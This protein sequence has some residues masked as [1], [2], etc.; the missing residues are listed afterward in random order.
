MTSLALG[1]TMRHC[2]ACPACGAEAPPARRRPGNPSSSADVLLRVM[3]TRVKPAYDAVVDDLKGFFLFFALSK[4]LGIML[5]PTNFLID[6]G[7]AG[8]VLL[9]TGLAS[10]GRRL[11]TVSLVLLALFGFSP[12][13]SLL[14]YPLESRFAPWDE[15]RGAPDGIVVLG[16]SIDPELSA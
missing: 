10:L 3:D 13:S 1:E 4:T 14:L 9:F 5:L 6:L 8:A 12:L 16:G 2:R 11:M 7:L 15:T